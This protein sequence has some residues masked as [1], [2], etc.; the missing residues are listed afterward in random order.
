MF[1]KGTGFPKHISVAFE[2]YK[3]AAERGHSGAQ[4][5]L[6]R[7][8]KDTY[9]NLGE[10]FKWFKLAAAQDHARA[11]YYLGKAYHYGS[12]VVPDPEK[13][14]RWYK[15]AIKNGNQNAEE[16]LKTLCLKHVST[17]DKL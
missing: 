8:Y 15:T 13:A 1:R 16:W 10:A 9:M 6:G 5:R 17:C 7:I 4:Y 3:K 12:G 2:W 11:Q 14:M